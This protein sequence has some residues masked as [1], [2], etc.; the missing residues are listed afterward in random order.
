MHEEL[1][2]ELAIIQAEKLARQKEWERCANGGWLWWPIEVLRAWFR[3][4]T[5]T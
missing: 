1:L 3:A 4:H 5:R 2:R